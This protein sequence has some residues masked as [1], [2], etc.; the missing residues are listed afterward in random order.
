MKKRFTTWM[1]T[2][3]AAAVLMLPAT[4]M[5]RDRDDWNRDRYNNGYYNGMSAHE[6]HEFE[7]RQRQLAAGTAPAWERAQQRQQGYQQR[8]STTMA[9]T[10]TAG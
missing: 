4:A 10:T 3:G 6:R 5:A 7:E 9:P 8:L 1:A 2:L